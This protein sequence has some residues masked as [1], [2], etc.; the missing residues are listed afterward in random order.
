[1]SDRLG[2]QGDNA[3]IAGPL[4]LV[5]QDHADCSLHLDSFAVGLPLVK[6][7]GRGI[8]QTKLQRQAYLSGTT[9][10]QDGSAV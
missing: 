7:V 1:M 4:N 8:H 5:H 6:R 9:L 2:Q 10:L 3:N